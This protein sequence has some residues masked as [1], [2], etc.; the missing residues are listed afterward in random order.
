MPGRV[1]NDLGRVI[2][3]AGGDG[4]RSDVRRRH[5]RFDGLRGIPPVARNSNSSLDA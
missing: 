3:A 1:S 2:K 5:D 4:A